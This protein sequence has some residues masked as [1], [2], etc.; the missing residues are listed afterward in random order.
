M[1]SVVASAEP[2]RIEYGLDVLAAFHKIVFTIAERFIPN[3]WVR[4]RYESI[5][6]LRLDSTLLLL[7]VG[8]D[9][10]GITKRHLFKKYR[11][12]LEVMKI[13]AIQRCNLVL[14][15]QILTDALVYEIMSY[16]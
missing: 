1:A 14:L 15:T 9:E 16:I 2:I 3:I 13:V 6:D 10:D 5:D 8:F 12:Q 4:L 7:I 11:K